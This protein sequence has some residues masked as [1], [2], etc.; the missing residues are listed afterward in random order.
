M[1]I[2]DT[3]SHIYSEQFDEDRDEMIH[4]AF[5]AG[6]EYILMPNVDV[7]SID[8]MLAI[9]DKYP[10]QCISMMGLHPTS[11]DEKYQE[12]LK[13]MRSWFDKRRFC[14]VGEIG[15]DLYWDK[16]FLSEQIKAFKT[17]IQWAI[18]LDLPIVIHARDAFDEIFEVLDNMDI[19]GLTGV[20]HSFTG[21][22]EQAK[23][24]LSYGCFKMSINGVVTFKNSGLGKVVE[25][26][27]IQDLVLETDAPYLTPTPFR[28]KRNE[29]AYTDLVSKKLA[30]LF[31]MSQDEVNSITSAS[32]KSL[33]K[34]K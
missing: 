30:E 34:L 33:F 13:I 19:T 3:H 14:A 25:Q 23:K 12:Q 7:E 11:V 18:D 31:N 27:S 20:F 21:N 15:I 10:T 6:V 24:V 32:A 28:G 22:I 2:I 8:A 9:E 16:T 1:S 17:Q 5:E 26:L 4:R 29:P